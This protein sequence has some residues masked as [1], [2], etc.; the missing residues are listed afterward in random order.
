MNELQ[1]LAWLKAMDLTPWVAR[2][3]LP[4]AAPSPELVWPEQAAAR[5]EPVTPADAGGEQ[6]PATPAPQVSPSRSVETSRSAEPAPRPPT[7]PAVAGGLRVTLQAHQA[8]EVWVLAEQSDPG[9]PDLGRDA[10]RLLH[11]LLKIFPGGGSQR[12]FVWPLSGLAADDAAAGPTFLSFVQALGNADQGARVLLCAREETVRAL[13][14]A[15]RFEPVAAG[16]AVL[17]PVASLDEMLADPVVHKRPS[18][19]AMVRAGFNG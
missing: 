3:P 10:L 4:G 16:N 15:A 5:V 7:R 9:A 18:W 17:L 2:Q 6:A 19:Q 8:G 14:G 1:R 11:N 13:A 12:R